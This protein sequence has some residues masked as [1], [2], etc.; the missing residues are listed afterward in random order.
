MFTA[1]GCF[2]CFL[3][4]RNS[5]TLRFWYI[6]ILVTLSSFNALKEVYALYFGNPIAYFAA[7]TGVCTKPSVEILAT[8]SINFV[9]FLAILFVTFKYYRNLVPD[10]QVK[11]PCTT[12]L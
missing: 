6:Y 10:R 8:I 7:K 4:C 11:K 2:L 5:G 9:P 1:A 3:E 12:V